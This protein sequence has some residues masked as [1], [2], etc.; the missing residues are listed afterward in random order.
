VLEKLTDPRDV[1]LHEGQIPIRHRYTPGVAGTAFF[2]ALKDR[3]V[4][5]ASPCQRCGITYCP[6]RLFCERCFDELRT[7]TEVGPEGTVASFT[8]GHV[9]VEG[10]P[11][12]EPVVV[13]LVQLEGADT[14]LLGFLW[15][16]SDDPPPTIGQR[17]KAV[18]KPASER[19]GSILDIEGFRP[20]GD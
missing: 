1:I 18:L 19:V 2:T 5:L 13:G 17:V 6:P 9:G 11:L 20:A 12:E 15:N 10:E 3:G 7:E 14:F 4:F 16:G 8:V